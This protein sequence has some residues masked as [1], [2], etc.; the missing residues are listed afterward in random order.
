MFW[1]HRWLCLKSFKPKEN[2]PAIFSQFILLVCVF[3]CLTFCFSYFILYLL[4]YICRKEEKS[5][6][7][8]NRKEFTW[9]VIWRYH[10]SYFGRAS[11]PTTKLPNNCS[12][13]KCVEPD[14]APSGKPWNCSHPEILQQLS[15]IGRC[16]LPGAA[17]II[18]ATIFTRQEKLTPDSGY[19]FLIFN[20]NEICVFL[21]DA[22]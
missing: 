20:I 7:E 16:R 2:Q 5:Y 10:C 3:Y 21:D 18:Q 17:G 4:R 22:G 8:F 14:E 9:A 15:N 12:L 13:E 1:I 6:D 19:R 11:R